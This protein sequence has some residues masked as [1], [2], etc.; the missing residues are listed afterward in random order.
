MSTIKG[1]AR[2]TTSI[3]RVSEGADVYIRMLRDGTVGVADL[4][5]LWSL[6][7]RIF[8]GTAGSGSS[9][10][11]F[12]ATG[13][14]DATTFDMHLAIPSSVVVIPLEYT[15]VYE[16]FG[17]ILLVENVLQYGTGSV[18]GTATADIPTS[19][20]P[21]AGVAS[22][23]TLNFASATGTA[24]TTIAE[25]L[26]HDS[27][28]PVI[29]RA[30]A[31]GNVVKER[32]SYNWKDTGVLQTVGPSQQLVAFAAAQAGTGFIK[33]VYAELPVGSV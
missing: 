32:F 26:W 6:E 24:L 21:N 1:K 13:T 33:F 20:N 15:V 25:E 29:T 2:Q 5:A 10:E 4:I 14:Y 28:Q 31:E 12:G 30:S 8:T 27:L 16:A 18:V 19:S 9:P 22:K 11:T 23:C 3:E 7:G 17:T